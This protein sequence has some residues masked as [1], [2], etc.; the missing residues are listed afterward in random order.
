MSLAVGNLEGAEQASAEAFH[1][2]SMRGKI[3]GP[4]EAVL[5]ARALVLEALGRSDEASDLLE[6][7]R[8]TV[9]GKAEKI[10]DPELRQRFLQEIPLNRAI[11]E[12]GDDQE[13]HHA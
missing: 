3:E 5:H 12:T 9:R 11:M 1:K 10:E 13:G 2:L 7:A 6:Q 4:E 8:A